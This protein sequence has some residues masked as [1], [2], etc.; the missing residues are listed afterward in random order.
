MSVMRSD[1][2]LALP[3]RPFHVPF[4]YPLPPFPTVSSYLPAF[5]PS[6]SPCPLQTCCASTPAAT[7]S[8]CPC[9]R[10]TSPP[11]TLPTQRPARPTRLCLSTKRGVRWRN[12]HGSQGIHGSPSAELLWWPPRHPPA[13][14][15]SAGVPRNTRC[16]AQ[17]SAS[18]ED[19]CGALGQF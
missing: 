11:S 16:F 1:V 2:A 12:G 3:P 10:A 14:G 5:T 15:P 17:Q 9:W 4:P 8:S 13:F 7:K 19:S 6:P 18:C